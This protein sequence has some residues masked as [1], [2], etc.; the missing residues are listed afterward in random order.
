MARVR[1]QAEGGMRFSKAAYRI[2]A[3]LDARIGPHVLML[4]VVVTDDVVSVA[5]E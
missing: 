4:E 3:G 5:L 1:A 2:T